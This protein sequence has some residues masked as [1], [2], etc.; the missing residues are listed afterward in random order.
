MSDHAGAKVSCIEERKQFKSSVIMLDFNRNFLIR[1]FSMAIS[2]VTFAFLKTSTAS[3]VPSPIQFPPTIGISQNEQFPTGHLQPLGYQRVP[4]GPVKEYFDVLRG[5][6][7]WEKHVGK[8]I[9]LV[10]RQGIGESPA[11]FTWTDD[12]LK[13]KYGDLDVLIELKQE[14]RSHPP[15]RMTIAEFLSRYEEEDMY[16]VTVLPDLMRRD[17]QVR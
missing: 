8:G 4:D 15:R 5:D 11:L 7:F 14:N 16:I 13:D 10:F 1:K 6:L 12:Y 3:S 2:F 9:P 17:V